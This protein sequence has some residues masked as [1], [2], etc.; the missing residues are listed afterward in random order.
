MCSAI[1]VSSPITV[2]ALGLFDLDADGL[3]ADHPIGLW[4]GDGTLLASTT[5]TNANGAIMRRV[6]WD[7]QGESGVFGLLVSGPENLE[8]WDGVRAFTAFN[9]VNKKN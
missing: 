2:G 8:A 7:T 6:F 3:L 1:C 4:A 5:I 9:L